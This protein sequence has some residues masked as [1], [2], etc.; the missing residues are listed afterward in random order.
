[1]REEL[2]DV[3]LPVI[4][5]EFKQD[6][7]ESLKYHRKI[8]NAINKSRRPL[9]VLGAG[10]QQYRN[11]V[12]NFIYDLG[13]PT[14]LTW[15]AI[16]ML[17]HD[18]PLNCRDFGVTSQRAGPFAMQ[19]ADLI[20]CL[21]T[22]LDTHETTKDW[23]PNAKKIIIDI[24]KAE[25]DKHKATHKFWTDIKHVPFE[26]PA[27]DYSTWLSNI[28]TLRKKY[29]LPKTMPYAFMNKLS[30]YANEK[31][32]IITDAGQTLTWTM[33][34]WKIKRHQRL[35]SAFNHSP[36]GYALP[37]SFGASFTTESNI[38]CI[39]GD[40]GL[41]MNIQ[42]L[43]TIVGYNKPIKIFVMDNGGYGMI[44]QT[45]SDWEEL[46]NDVACDPYTIPLK[47]VAKAH[48]IPYYEI[49]N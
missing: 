13:I 28:Q 10:A 7:K 19:N 15:G 37:A 47:N 9:L 43:Q 1:Q 41:Q 22:R 44:K 18:H 11:Q 23:A 24:D 32:V 20:I 39:T 29:P 45:Q 27:N 46:R 12:E 42:D 49:N 25:L 6:E 34:S 30:Q 3:T 16:D 21:G 35:F 2:E 33:Q 40:G 4:E 38:I 14:F 26:R 17:P 48:G 31:D 8:K 36:M 5:L